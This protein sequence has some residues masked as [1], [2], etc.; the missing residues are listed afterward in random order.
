MGLF[1]F[2]RKETATISKTVKK[3]A[4]KRTAPHLIQVR[5]T[6][7]EKVKLAK[8]AKANE[9]TASQVIRELIKRLS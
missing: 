6:K 7:A 2:G 8:W 9:M 3:K 1:S 5:A 4:A